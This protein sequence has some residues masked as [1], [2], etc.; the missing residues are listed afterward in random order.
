ML[1]GAHLTAAGG[2]LLIGCGLYL[3]VSR[4]SAA[5]SL[6]GADGAGGIPIIA[7]LPLESCLS[8]LGGCG[9]K[10]CKVV[11]GITT[12][13]P[14]ACASALSAGA[15]LGLGEPAAFAAL[16]VRSRGPPL[17]EPTPGAANG[18]CPN[19][20]PPRARPTSAAMEAP[21]AGDAPAL[22]L[23]PTWIVIF[24][25]WAGVSMLCGILSLI[26]G[27]AGSSGSGACC[28]ACFNCS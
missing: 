1:T 12:G 24:F 19:G 21:G 5:V 26:L 9:A 23:P 25:G 22:D 6:G 20:V 7:M 4:I 28:F 3:C 2:Y 27:T 14:R 10:V 13:D 15:K 8:T 17:T 16:L 18:V 11:F